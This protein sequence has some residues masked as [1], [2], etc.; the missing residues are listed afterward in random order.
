M[1]T[2]ALK[3]DSYWPV[4]LCGATLVPMTVMGAQAGIAQGTSRWGSLT[5]IYVGNGLGRLVGGTIALLVS[6][7]RPRP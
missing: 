4:I 7:R 6:R 2:P 3:L 1:L 5:A